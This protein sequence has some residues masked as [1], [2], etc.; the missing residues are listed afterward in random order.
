MTRL[1]GTVGLGFGLLVSLAAA[2]P[3]AAQPQGRAGVSEAQRLFEQGVELLEQGRYD[4]ALERFVESYGLEAQPV[5]LL[6]IGMCRKVLGD[7]PAAHDALERYLA[8]AGVGAHEE[9]V[10]SAHQALAEIELSTGTIVLDVDPPGA[11]VTVDG[12]A[13]AA[14]ELA[15]PLRVLPGTHVVEVR[16]EGRVADRRTI[17]VGAGSEVQLVLRLLPAAPTTD[18]GAASAA[19]DGMSGLEL[20]AWIGVGAAAAAGVTAV[21]TGSLGLVSR[22]DFVAGGATDAGLR[23]EVVDLGLATDVM[24]GVAA[25]GAVAALV[26]FLLDAGDE[27]QRPA[28][29]AEDGGEP[30]AVLA[31]PGGVVVTW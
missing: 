10:S 14:A 27:E 17:D 28:E 30:T 20:G 12:G 1:A 3:A 15:W 18:G 16:Q 13:L 31:F 9:L 11:V 19:D 22:D 5:V 25:A 2:A 23:Q 6:N 8:E 21:V 4:E 24:L 29:A 26:L 7:L